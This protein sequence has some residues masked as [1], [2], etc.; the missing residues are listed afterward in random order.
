MPTSWKPRSRKGTTVSDE[1]YSDLISWARSLGD[2]DFTLSV[3]GHAKT[4]FRKMADALE[5]VI[6]E[7]D[8]TREQYEL[9]GEPSSL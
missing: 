1:E 3:P 8:I 2:P 9:H 4:A 5:E 7:R 6:R